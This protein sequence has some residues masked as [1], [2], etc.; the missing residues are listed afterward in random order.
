MRALKV[1]PF[2][3]Y[4]VLLVL[5]AAGLPLVR[6]VLRVVLPRLLP[7]LFGLL[8]VSKKSGGGGGEL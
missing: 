8:Q 4:T 6:W 5:A 1:T 2:F 7:A 3:K